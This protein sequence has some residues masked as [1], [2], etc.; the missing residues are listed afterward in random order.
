[1]PR[2][3]LWL[4]IGLGLALLLL[5][6]L[7]LQ[8]VNQLIWNLSYWL[9]GWLVGPLLLLLVA[10]VALAVAQVGLPWLRALASGKGRGGGSRQADPAAALPAG[11]RREA[12]ERNLAAI[13]Q[14]LGSSTDQLRYLSSQ[15]G[16]YGV[17]V[18]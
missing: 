5:V 18:L 1:M 7:V 4:W 16:Q 11:S 17:A 12:A 10:C 13:D 15:V 3:R 6:G 2:R 9:P 14:T 8:A